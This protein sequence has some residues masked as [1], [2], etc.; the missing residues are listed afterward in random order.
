MDATRCISYL[1][2]EHKGTIDEG[3][4]DEMGRQVFGCDI[5]QD[6]CP[7][8][9]PRRAPISADPE[10]AA[11]RELVNP[12]LDWLAGMDEGEFGRQFSGSPVRRAGF[13]GFR[14][15][16]A[17]AIGNSGVRALARYLVEWT[18]DGREEVR[19]VARWALRKLKHNG[20][21]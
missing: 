18:E 10:L 1:T 9:S 20:P 15:D 8:N 21:G 3:L 12:A 14:R 11:R 5:C 13:A 7:W 4:M 6:V 17:I 16:V 2:I 19:S